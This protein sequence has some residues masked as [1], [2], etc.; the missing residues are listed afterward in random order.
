MPAWEKRGAHLAHIALYA[1]VM[2]V[3]LTGWAIV[4]A[5]PLNIPTFA[6]N[7]VLIPHL[8][9]PVSEAAEDRWSDVHETLAKI[10]MAVR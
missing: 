10:V 9:L 7:T 8:P 2:L 4:S 3:P 5:S 1:G 6:Y